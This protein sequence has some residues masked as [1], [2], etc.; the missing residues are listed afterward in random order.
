MNFYYVTVL[1]IE[2]IFHGRC[3]SSNSNIY[4]ASSII[5]QRYPLAIFVHCCSHVLNLSIASSCSDVLVSN[6]MGS[7]REVRKFFEHGKCQDKLTEVIEAT[8]PD[9]KKLN[10]CPERV[11]LNVTMP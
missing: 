11:E 4:G 3:Q 1:S 8:M 9:T 10:P 2:P 6:M 7:I 5:R